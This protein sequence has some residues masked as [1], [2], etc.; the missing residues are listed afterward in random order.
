MGHSPRLRPILQNYSNVSNNVYCE[1]CASTMHNTKQCRALDALEKW[2]DKPSYRVNEAPRGKAGGMRGGR[3][4]RRGP[5]RCYNCDQE[6]HVA[7]EF[8]LPRRP[9][10]SQCRVNT[11]TTEDCPELIKRWEERARQRGKN[12]VNFEPRII[13]DQNMQSVA[14][15][16][17]GG[18][19][20]GEVAQGMDSIKLVRPVSSKPT[21]RLEK[22]KQFF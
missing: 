13:E 15:V 4:G 6:G 3:V 9:W 7:R 5:V 18:K 10:C 12:L 16:T 8:P 19:R 20:T 21:F 1:F 14:I 11:H 2:L 22:Q 17:R